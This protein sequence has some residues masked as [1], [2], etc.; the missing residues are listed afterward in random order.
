MYDIKIF[1]NP[2]RKEVEDYVVSINP[3]YFSGWVYALR[4]G[5]YFK[6]GCSQNI[7]ERLYLL[8]KYAESYADIK[9]GEFIVSPPCLNY[10]KLETF[11]HNK[12]SDNRKVGTELFSVCRADIIKAF[13]SLK[14]DNDYKHADEDFERRME[15]LKSVF[16]PKNPDGEDSLEDLMREGAEMIEKLVDKLNESF[17]IINGMTKEIDKAIEVAEQWKEK[18]NMYRDALLNFIL[19]S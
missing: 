11:I 17:E 1:E 13:E 2:T 15:I 19:Q 14:Y 12:F 4:Y 9:T 6:I 10:R 18:A 7:S 5:D 3:H 16:K 8:K